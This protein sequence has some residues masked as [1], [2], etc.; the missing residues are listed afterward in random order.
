MSMTDF[1]SGVCHAYVHFT[2][3]HF[4]N[5][6]IFY[7]TGRNIWE[8]LPSQLPGDKPALASPVYER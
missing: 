6:Q 2:T 1:P 4:S 7:L 5:A 8:Q 3:R